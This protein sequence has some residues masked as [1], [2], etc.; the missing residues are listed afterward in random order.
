MILSLFYLDSAA[1]Y[2]TKHSLYSSWK[3]AER[4]DVAS[5]K[6]CHAASHSASQV[7]A[8][9]AASLRQFT[10]CSSRKMPMM[11]FTVT[12]DTLT[13]DNT[14]LPSCSFLISDNEESILVIIL[15]RSQLIMT[16]IGLVANIGTSTTLIKNGQ[17]GVTIN[18]SIVKLNSGK[19]DLE[20]L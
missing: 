1:F 12:N 6:S 13:T 5:T 14:N 3:S 19:E 11:T 7:A 8:F 20:K 15:D 17:V 4:A 16:S 2:F 10:R 18:G 9:E